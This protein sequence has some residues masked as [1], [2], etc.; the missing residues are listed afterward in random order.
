MRFTM[1][2]LFLF[3]STANA[4]ITLEKMPEAWLSYLPEGFVPYEQAQYSQRLSIL[5][6]RDHNVLVHWS[7]NDT[8]FRRV[9][10]NR[11]DPYAVP[12][13]LTV[14][15]HNA[16]QF[17]SRA[18]ILFPNRPLRVFT[19]KVNA[20]A[21]RLLPK[22]SWTFPKETVV[23]DVLMNDKGEP[24]EIRMLEG[25]TNH[26]Q[27][28]PKIWFSDLSKAPPGYKPPKVGECMNCHRDAG[29]Q[30][31]YG[32]GIRGSDGIF[33]FTPFKDGTFEIDTRWP[34]TQ[35]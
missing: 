25:G 14:R 23:A 29:K 1:M 13:G 11:L 24:F 19:E 4:Q 33:S 16:G 2:V 22:K 18:A 21:E 12:G 17:S 27:W 9:N 5:N 30:G 20:N 32:T 31:V 28:F 26:A 8:L 6:E 7:T 3:A 34:I 15:H 35:K 10:P